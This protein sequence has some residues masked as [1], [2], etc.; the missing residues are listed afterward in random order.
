MKVSE[1]FSSVSSDR[2]RLVLEHVVRHVL[3][4][5]ERAFVDPELDVLHTNGRPTSTIEHEAGPQRDRR[6]TLWSY[7]R[8]MIWVT[9]ITFL[10]GEGMIVT[11]GCIRGV[12][13]R[14]LTYLHV[15]TTE[16][17]T[18]VTLIKL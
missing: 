12:T 5:A 14:T 1:A 15:S 6:A 17:S 8:Q 2:R 9:H 16:R 18:T 7:L 10:S 11:G 3:T 4:Q 13:V